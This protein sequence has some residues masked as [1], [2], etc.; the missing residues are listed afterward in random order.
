MALNWRTLRNAI[1]SMLG[2]MED[3]K[4]V[5]PEEA[6]SIPAVWH[7]ISKIGGHVGQLPLHV[8][9]RLD[10][11]AEKATDHPAYHLV[12]N[13]PTPL[14]S[15]FDWKELSMVHALLWGNARS[16]I[17]RDASGRPME[18]LPLHP[19]NTVCVLFQ[20]QKY[21]VT[22]PASESRESLFRQFVIQQDDM[23]IIP[24]ADVLHIKGISFDGID[25][26]GS[27]PTHKR[28]LRIAI[29]SE[30]SLENQLS[31]GFAG[32]I[33][34]EAPAGAFADEQDAKRF[35]EAFKAHHN[36]S[37]KAGQIG[38]L[39]EGIKA[40]VISM[41]S[42]DMQM[43]EQR[44]FSRQ[45]IAL[46]FGLESILGDN[47]S[48]CHNSLEQKKLAYLLDTLM[49]WLVKWEQEL[50]YKLLSDQ[51]KQ[52]DSHYFKFTD[53]ALLRADSQT[54]SQ[55]LSTYITAR[56]ISPNEARAMLDL[57]PYEGGDDYANPA[58]D[59]RPTDIP[60][61]DDSPENEDDDEE[62]DEPP[63]AAGRRAVVSRLRN[64]LGV[65]AKRA[66]DGCRQKNFAD[67][68]E[69]FYASWEGKLAEVIAEVGGDPN[70]ASHHCEE[71]KRQLIEASGRVK[72]NEELAAEVGQI[73][74]DWPERRAEE[75]ATIILKG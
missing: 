73:V 71:S 27:I 25:G 21:H 3:S 6:I 23:L 8:Y 45:D 68:A 74:A 37:E 55:I 18:I 43:I 29:D 31:K 57:N 20:G 66:V 39:R 48:V 15:A 62:E 53:R 52:A 72:T 64:L 22:K 42:V 38:L 40:N 56:V 44:A 69:K 41:S 4:H 35:V 67:W 28:T 26:K 59:T 19:D 1:G 7:A 2:G 33:L 49:R 12:R 54:Q 75:L 17:V 24:D 70:L 46:L 16:W 63:R 5:G 50:D 58:I 36:G 51:E 13:R 9:R 11:G 34:L 47:A 65:E 60:E 14:L 61:P 32:S 30:R 10:R